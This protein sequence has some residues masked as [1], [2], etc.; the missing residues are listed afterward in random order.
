MKFKQFL[1]EAGGKHVELSNE[2]INKL[3]EWMEDYSIGLFFGVYANYHY[4]GGG[5]GDNKVK[6]KDLIEKWNSN[7]SFSSFNPIITYSGPSGDLEFPPLFDLSDHKKIDI[8]S[9]SDLSIAS[10][11]NF[12]KNTS[13]KLNEVRIKSFRGVDKLGCKQLTFGF[14]CS[15]APDTPVLALFKDEKLSLKDESSNN[16]LKLLAKLKADGADLAEVT[17]KLHDENLEQYAKF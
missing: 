2:N 15:I 13:F 5:H 6:A 4:Y 1:K 14:G 8:E 3:A 12:P 7:E 16:L 9:E 17:E 11:E 10:F